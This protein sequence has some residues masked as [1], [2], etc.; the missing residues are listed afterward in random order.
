MPR[1]PRLSTFEKGQIV[2]YQSNCWP[3]SRIAEEIG[4]SR[5]VVNAFLRDQARYNRKNPGGGPRK[6]TAADQRRI[7]REASKGVLSSAGIV[8]AL[9]LNVKARRVRQV[10]Q[11]NKNLR[12][13]RVARTP[14]TRERHEEAHVSW[15]KGTMA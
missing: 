8:K 7:N 13:K 12:Y 6:L 3:V 5:N 11:A 1:K 15:A 9:Q 4:R 14:A 10:L 2:A